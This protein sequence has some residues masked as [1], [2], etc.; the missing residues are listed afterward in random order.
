MIKSIELQNFR[1]FEKIKI[2]TNQKIIIFS[3][4]NATGKTTLLEAIYLASTSK[5]HRSNDLNSLIHE[6]DPYA[7]LVITTTSKFKIVLSREGKS[8]YINQ[9]EYKRMSDFI[10]HLP[11]VMFSPYDLELIH[12]AKTVRRRFLDL[13]I[14][15]LD[16]SYLRAIMGYKKVLKERNELLK[17]YTPSNQLALKIITTQ[18]E[19]YAVLLIKKRR[20][21]IDLMNQTLKMITSSLDCEQIELTYESTLDVN[22]V[23]KTY[24]AKLSYDIM[25][26]TTNI[27]PHRDDFKI[28]INQQSANLYASE[29]QKRTIALS[30]K[31]ALLEIYKSK[32][33]VSPILLLDDVFAALDQ[34]RI[35]HIMKYIKN[36]D[37]T[38]ITTT[39][40]LNIPDDLLRDAK[41]IRV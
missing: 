32:I 37:Q 29:G 36:I 5:S 22:Q 17:L 27:G 23:N 39:S 25:T 1:R 19:E 33:S 28:D 12:G 6:L 11:V 26:K 15:L 24:E 35:N 14:S 2:D 4:P 7:S 3:G 40:I 20:E 38:F 13:E 8:F 41:V 10:G 30:L 16:K 34:K 21:F 18:L 9:K 31:L